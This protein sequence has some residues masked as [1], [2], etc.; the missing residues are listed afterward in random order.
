MK[1]AELEKF[2]RMIL[3][4]CGV[5]MEVCENGVYL[6]SRNKSYVFK[7]AE[8]ALE[9]VKSEQALAQVATKA[10]E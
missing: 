9:F 7:T 10:D 2:A 8:E 4:L 1:D 6:R 3:G 5:K